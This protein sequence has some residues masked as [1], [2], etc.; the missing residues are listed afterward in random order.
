MLVTPRRPRKVR[1]VMREGRP[2]LKSPKSCTARPF[3]CPVTP[4]HLADALFDHVKPVDALVDSTLHVVGF[5]ALRPIGAGPVIGFDDE[6]AQTTKARRQ[7]LLVVHHPAAMRDYDG[8]GV[9]FEMAEALPL[10]TGTDEAS[11]ADHILRSAVD[12]VVEICFDLEY[13]PKLLVV[14]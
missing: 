5:H 6:V 14:S 12:L 9:A 11:V 13:L 4:D 1:A 3:T 8:D 7:L 10:R 2:K